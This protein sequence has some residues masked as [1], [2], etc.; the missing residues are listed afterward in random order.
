MT[1]ELRADEQ[2]ALEKLNQVARVERAIDRAY[3]D[4]ATSLVVDGRK[5]VEKYVQA[6]KDSIK[7]Y[8]SDA[9]EPFIYD[10]ELQWIARLQHRAGPATYD[11]VTCANTGE[12]AQSILEAAKAGMLRVD[13][14]MLVRFRKEA[15]AHWADVIERYRM[16]GTGSVAL[17]IGPEK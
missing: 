16:A 6:L 3:E 9:P 14:K 7:E 2:I 5:G 11:L 10:G 8:L 17:L 15:G 4:I 13:D 12:G 1:T